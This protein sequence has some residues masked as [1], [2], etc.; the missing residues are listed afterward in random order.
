VEGIGHSV[1]EVLYGQLCGGTKE[2]KETLSQDSGIIH[3][4]RRAFSS[5]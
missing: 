2:N 4:K 1:I 3:R 5:L